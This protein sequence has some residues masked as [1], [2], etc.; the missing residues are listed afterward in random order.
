MAVKYSIVVPVY[1]EE[2]A[3]AGFLGE[4]KGFLASSGISAEVIIVDDGST[5]GS[6][7]EAEKSGFKLISHPYN[8]GYGAALKTGARASAGEFIVFIDG[9]GQHKPSDISLLLDESGNYDMVVGARV[10]DKTASFPRK[11]AKKILISLANYLSETRILDLNSGFRTVRKTMLM[12]YIDYLPNAFSFTTTITVICIKSGYNL[13]Y[14]PITI[15]KRVGKSKI[16]PFTDFTRFM[17][18]LIRTTMLFTPLK[19]FLPMSLLL[20][21]VGFID[22]ANNLMVEANIADSSVFLLTTSVLLFS[23]GLLS[24]QISFL[25]R[26]RD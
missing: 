16:N 26:V 11:I 8:K 10:F 19:V 1:N 6:R 4:L 23:F 7:A 24:D 17:M 15:E 2:G 12:D 25:R 20:G 21:L 13:K 14:V 22:L 18:L 9:D 5:D 3:I